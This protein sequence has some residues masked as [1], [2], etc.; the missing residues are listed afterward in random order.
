MSFI[1]KLI[2]N[3]S[4]TLIVLT[5]GHTYGADF[6]PEGGL[7]FNLKCTAH[8][9]AV[10]TKYPDF[11]Y[12][13]VRSD[14]SKICGLQ[15]TDNL[16][17]NFDHFSSKLDE[18]SKRLN[19]N[20]DESVK[21]EYWQGE[22]KI[23]SEAAKPRGETNVFVV[24]KNELYKNRIDQTALRE[25]CSESSR[26]R[27]GASQIN[28]CVK[29]K[30]EEEKRKIN[31]DLK[32]LEDQVESEKSA[33]QGISPTQFLSSEQNRLRAS[34]NSENNSDIEAVDDDVVNLQEESSPV[35]NSNAPSLSPTKA[36][37][38]TIASTPSPEESSSE[39]KISDSAQIQA[40][41]ETEPEQAS[42]DEDKTLTEDTKESESLF[43]SQDLNYDQD[44][45]ATL[46]FGEGL[47]VPV[48][49]S[50]VAAMEEGAAVCMKNT[51]GSNQDKIDKCTKEAEKA[52]ISDSN[53]CGT[54]HNQIKARA[55]FQGAPPPEV[56]VES[57]SDA[58]SINSSFCFKSLTTDN[59]K[60]TVDPQSGRELQRNVSVISSKLAAGLAGSSEEDQFG[61]NEFLF[62]N[63]LDLVRFEDQTSRYV[64]ANSNSCNSI[65]GKR[66]RDFTDIEGLLTVRNKTNFCK[67]LLQVGVD[68]KVPECQ[69]LV[70]RIQREKLFEGGDGCKPSVGQSALN[71][72]TINQLKACKIENLG[73]N[74]TMGLDAF[75]EEGEKILENRKGVYDVYEGKVVAKSALADVSEVCNNKTKPLS[76]DEYVT[77]ACN[78][79]TTQLMQCLNAV[80]ASPNNGDKIVSG[81]VA[82][83]KVADAVKAESAS[84]EAE[85]SLDGKI[86]CRRKLSGSSIYALDYG[87]CLDVID[88]YN[89]T[90][91]VVDTV[92]P[93]VGQAASAM[94]QQSSSLAANR[95]IA[96][97]GDPQKAAFKAQ[98]DRLETQERFEKAQGALQGS[99]ALITMTKFSL[100]PTPGELERWAG[101]SKPYYKNLDRGDASILNA[102]VGSNASMMDE[103]FANQAANDVLVTNAIDALSKGIV[104]A[105]RAS[106]FRKQR[107]L[108]KKVEDTLD[109]AQFNKPENQLTK[110]PS[111]CEVNPNLASC[112]KR[113]SRSRSGQNGI[114]FGGF[115]A[116]SGGGQEVDFDLDENDKNSIISKGANPTENPEREN[117]ESILD[118]TKVAEE[119]AFRAPGAAQ[120][121]GASPGGGGGGGAGGGAG[122]VAAAGGGGGGGEPPNKG[123]SG[124]SSDY[125][126][127]TAGKYISGGGKVSYR[128]GAGRGPAGGRRSSSNPFGGL[129]R[130]RSKRAVASEVEKSLLPKKMKLFDAISS[131]YAKVHGSDR[132]EKSYE[133]EPK[134]K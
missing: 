106:H 5:I 120:I 125:G 112:R 119:K 45:Y 71:S 102:L 70:V 24:D 83:K 37:E 126:K 52:C 118:D 35:E 7:R 43:G 113:G 29:R 133:N 78:E 14:H 18:I 30:E 96:S 25:S 115:S 130:Q 131:R 38:R 81:C 48:H 123:R 53:V 99:K 122:G 68:M 66:D 75:S 127:K 34:F 74:Y 54:Y 42:S 90:F 111:F 62:S 88:W 15:T 95:A 32:P 110:G 129:K 46:S 6:T 13:E 4:C 73:E 63:R 27:R 23:L 92:G 59:D 104:H 31:A 19:S 77:R 9:N 33:S 20:K 114:N 108:V 50:E 79:A 85:T 80:E 107:N 21:K 51:E 26:V 1:Y 55:A 93:I 12:N 100:Y 41:P 64:Y 47:Q 84:D 3:L 11:R 91:L 103:L 89:A 44:G 116:G 61:G 82:L 94:S 67:D 109:E 36:S 124:A 76:G 39:N 58:N 87:A 60:I 56:D 17:V 132:L 134:V 97:G 28:R 86:Q 117:V 121:T 98:K 22:I 105:I 128:S 101:G 8:F 72:Q 69:D 2:R 40:K 10:L 49:K 16:L 65:F 57:G